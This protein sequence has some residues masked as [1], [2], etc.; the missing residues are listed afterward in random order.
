M[1]TRIVNLATVILVAIG[2][3]FGFLI[4]YDYHHS[5]HLISREQAFAIAVKTGNWSQSFL[6]NTTPEAK[7]LHVTTDQFAYLV[8]EK[9]LYDIVPYCPANAQCIEPQGINS[10]G[11]KI[12]QYIWMIKLTGKPPNIL[13]GREWGYAIDATNG[14]VLR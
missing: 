12:G 8:D 6:D 7:L 13:S 10:H 5:P 14:Q 3:T 9:T 1:K 2:V 11:Y 4:L